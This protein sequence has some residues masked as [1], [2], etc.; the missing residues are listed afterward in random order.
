[1]WSGEPGDGSGRLLNK[2]EKLLNSSSQE[3]IRLKIKQPKSISAMEPDKE[4]VRPQII[5]KFNKNIKHASFFLLYLSRLL[6]YLFAFN[7]YSLRNITA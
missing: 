6:S 7:G 2:W 1:M 5:L 4:R 3:T